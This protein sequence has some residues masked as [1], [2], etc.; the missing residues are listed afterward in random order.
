[1][2]KTRGAGGVNDWRRRPDFDFRP[3]LARG[4][5]A[6]PENIFG[7]KDEPLSL[8]SV[9][10]ELERVPVIG[11]ETDRELF[12]DLPAMGLAAPH[13]AESRKPAEREFLSNDFA[14]GF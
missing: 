3:V 8:D 4:G 6:M 14:H 9:R 10:D 7:G 1:V 13:I 12:L 5:Q 2:K 11:R